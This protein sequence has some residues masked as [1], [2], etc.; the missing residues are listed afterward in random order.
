MARIENFLSEIKSRN[1]F[2]SRFEKASLKE[3]QKEKLYE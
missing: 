3:L 2:D 1:A